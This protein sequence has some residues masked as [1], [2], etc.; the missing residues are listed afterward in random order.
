MK[1]ST[2]KRDDLRQTAIDLAKECAGLISAQMNNMRIGEI[3]VVSPR[4]DVPVRFRKTSATQLTLLGSSTGFTGMVIA[5]TVRRLNGY[6]VTQ[7]TTWPRAEIARFAI[8]SSGS[9]RR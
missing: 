2:V 8:S 7:V 5:E 6:R 9:K 3:S 1:A 4:S